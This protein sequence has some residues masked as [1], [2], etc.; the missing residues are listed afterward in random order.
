MLLTC[1]TT[2][3]CTPSRISKY[4]AHAFILS[5][6][7]EII[8]KFWKFNFY[9]CFWNNDSEMKDCSVDLWNLHKTLIHTF[10]V[11]WCKW[12]KF[13][14][15]LQKV[16]RAEHPIGLFPVELTDVICICVMTF[17]SLV[18]MGQCFIYDVS[19]VC[20]NMLNQLQFRCVLVYGDSLVCCN[21]IS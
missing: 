15:W 12:S 19:I 4:D 20:S 6:F 1:C 9:Q 21:M 2:F 8:S 17:V 18:Q 5:R 7:I 14:I 3:Y 11:T 10:N 13:F 16:Y